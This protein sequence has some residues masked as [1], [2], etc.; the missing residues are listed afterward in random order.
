V[1][2]AEHASGRTRSATVAVVKRATAPEATPLVYTEGSLVEVYAPPAQELAELDPST[3]INR[4]ISQ[5][6][7]GNVREVVVLFA[8]SDP[9][10]IERTAAGDWPVQFDAE[11]VDRT[12]EVFSELSGVS[13][14]SAT[15]SDKQLE[16]WLL[17]PPSR[18]FVFRGEGGDILANVTI[19]GYPDADHFYVRGTERRVYTVPIA[20]L[21]DLPVDVAAYAR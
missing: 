18:R 3:L 11:R 17:Q 2:N 1:L 16:E 19:G 12:L 21:S 5:F 10:R 7:P 20:L 4:T 8:G 15:P 6:E 9:L 14:V 13:V